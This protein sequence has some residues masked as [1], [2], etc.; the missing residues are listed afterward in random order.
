MKRALTN[1]ELLDRYIHATMLPPDIAAE[2]RSNLESLVE[3]RAR[4]LG[5]EP[6]L[7]EFSAMLKRHGHPA[8]VASR[9]R[10]HTG[11]GL[12]SP[13]WFPLYRFTLIAIWALIFVIKV[14][15]AAFTFPGQPNTG[16]FL[17]Q[18]GL[19][20]LLS[21]FFIFGGVTLVYAALEYVEF[22]Y[23][24]SERWKPESLPAVPS[25]AWQPQIKRRPMVEVM[26]G[27]AGLIFLALA[28]YSPWLSWAWG[29]RGIFVP[30]ETL[31]A[32]RLPLLLLAMFWTS[33]SWAGHTRFAAAKWRRYSYTGVIVAGL[34]LAVLLL[35]TGDLLVP[36]PQWD[37]S[38]TKS[39]TT[40]NRMVSGTLV[41]ACLVAGLVC[42]SELRQLGRRWGSNRQAANSTS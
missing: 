2:I 33:L 41:L 31:S 20:I 42:V 3:D 40:L 26:G 28:L 21:G 37:P 17:L 22:K 16:S 7:E 8:V 5:R 23:R 4:Q 35:R 9:Y 32:M 24:L 12:I 39:L 6:S 27:V 18:F 36:G 10:S 13:E 1:Q 19:D 38:Q 34:V 11:R 14:I 15:A 25:P 30:S 29:G